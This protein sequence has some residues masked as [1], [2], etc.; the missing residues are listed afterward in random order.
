[1]RGTLTD[2]ILQQMVDKN[3]S[4]IDDVT[5]IAVDEDCLRQLEQDQKELF[6]SEGI[7]M[8]A[9]ELREIEEFFAARIVLTKHKLDNG[10]EF[11]QEV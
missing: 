3:L 6:A 7:E 5:H 9:I 8:D 10:Y 11:L 1:M 4:N 2:R